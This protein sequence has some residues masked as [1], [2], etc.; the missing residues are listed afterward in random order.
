MANSAQIDQM[1]ERITDEVFFTLGFKKRGVIRKI[2]GR[3]FYLPTNRFAR[4]FAE[5]DEAVGRDG[6][7]AGCRIVSDHLRVRIN[8]VGIENLACDGPMMVLSNHPG[9]YDSVAIGSLVP[10][11]DLRIVVYDVPFYHT[12]SE[13][14]P[15]LIYVPDDPFGRMV[16][17]RTAIQHLQNG[18]AL[19]QFGAGTIEPDPAVQPGAVEM[20]VHWSPSVEI[21]LRKAPDTSII[22][23]AAS[24]V[25]LPRFFNH[26]VAR[27]R[28]QPLARRRLAEFIQILQQLAIPGSIHFEARLRFAAPVKVTDLLEQAGFNRLMPEIIQAEH[29]LL[30]E[31]AIA[32]NLLL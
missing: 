12:L 29:R 27:L 10:R 25:L 5:A 19:L 23:A 9:A 24:G 30:A 4:M 6:I 7:P 32:N 1:R 13:I 22:L 2:F 21:M 15:R 20:L 18:G 14:G 3:L 26:P 16:A 28:R 8:A 17:L 11:K 31:E